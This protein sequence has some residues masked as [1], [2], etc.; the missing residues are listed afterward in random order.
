MT[1]FS[2]F[3]TNLKTTLEEIVSG[4][5]NDTNCMKFQKKHERKFVY[6]PQP[7]QFKKYPEQIPK[8]LE[9]IVIGNEG[10]ALKES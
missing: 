6:P 3:S 10:K 8:L 9:K 7:C 1:N 2:S 4:H 5:H